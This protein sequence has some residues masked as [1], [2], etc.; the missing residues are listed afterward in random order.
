MKKY[1]DMFGGDIKIPNIVNEKMEDAFSEIKNV[2]NIP[3]NKLNDAHAKKTKKI[4]FFRSHAAAVAC[5]CI[6]MLG[7]ITA[8][9][10][11]N[12]FWSRGMQGTLQ[13]TE[14][15]QQTLV[16]EGVA[17]IFQQEE[18]YVHMA[19]SDEGITVTPEMMVV[20]DKMVYISLSV[21]GFHLDDGEEPCFEFVD[22]YMG[23]DPE[24][25]EGWLMTGA[26]FYDGI[27]SGEDGTNMYEDG[28]PLILD[29]N[30]RLVSYYTDEEGKMEYI[31]V[32]MV[33]R[34]EDS[35]LGKDLH[36][37]LSNLGTVYK[38][39]FSENIEGNWDFTFSLPNVSSTKEITIGSSIDDTNFI[40]DSMEISPVSI[41]INYSVDNSDTFSEMI[42]KFNGVVLEDG[43]IIRNML[44]MGKSGYIDE[45]LSKAY[46]ISSFNRIIKIEQVSAIILEAKNGM[47]VIEVN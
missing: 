32:A 41:K 23:D 34:P 36:V 4:M 37:N 24:A 35:M 40:V 1:T 7:S 19:V 20:N 17:K 8:Y 5:I 46:A 43:T 21:D 29:E 11:Y 18:S 27:I 14:Q 10:V 26:S 39:D 38:T 15:Q 28:S 33:S 47:K 44:D 22:V 12:N 13:S 25:V 45:S 16:E 6:L 42:P 9:A 31:I 3:V 2:E 30:G